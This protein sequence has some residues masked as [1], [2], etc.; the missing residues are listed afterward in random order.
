MRFKLLLIGIIAA[1]LLLSACGN[2][3]SREDANDV[4]NGKVEKSEPKVIAFNN[5]YP[6]VQTKCDGFGHRI[7][8]TTHD[9]STG[10]NLYVIPD[11]TC[12]GPG[13]SYEDILRSNAQPPVETPSTDPSDY[14]GSAVSP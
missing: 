1:A 13:T 5:H 14:L 9:S 7:Y 6:N 8:V 11:R 2:D 12:Q 10:D 3:E 4:E